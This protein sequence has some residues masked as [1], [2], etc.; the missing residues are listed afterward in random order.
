MSHFYGVIDNGR[1]KTKATRRGFKTSGLETI[2]AS[3]NGAIQTILYYDEKTGRDMYQVLQ[4]SWHGQ[5]QY[6]LIAE[7]EVGK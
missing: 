3:W 7:G 1:S 5:G 6:K 4:T 2:A